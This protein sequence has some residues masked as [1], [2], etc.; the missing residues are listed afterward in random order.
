MLSWLIIK[1]CNVGFFSIIGVV[2]V[3]SDFDFDF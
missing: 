2:D 3:V 1:S